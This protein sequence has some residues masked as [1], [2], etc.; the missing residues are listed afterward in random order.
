MGHGP[1]PKTTWSGLLTT[2]ATTHALA[3]RIGQLIPCGGIIAL[4]GP[5]GVGKTAFAQG[6][7]AGLGVDEPVTSPTFTLMHRYEG[8]CPACHIDLYRLEPAAGLSDL[9]PE[10]EEVVDDVTVLVIEWADR[11]GAWLPTDH[12]AVE[13]SYLPAAAE[14][15]RIVLTA[16]GPRHRRLLAAA[17]SEEGTGHVDPGS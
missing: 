14:G 9:L 7:L 5:L 1:G 4:T 6:L 12:L 3:H 15:R 8:R 11:L 2:A 13:L 10:L 17:V 16:G